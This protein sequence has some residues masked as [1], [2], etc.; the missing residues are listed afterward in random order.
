MIV[1]KLTLFKSH[2]KFV[3][4]VKKVSGEQPTSHK[5]LG[6]CYEIIMD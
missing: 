5:A 6:D 2:W 4:I 3:D 1:G